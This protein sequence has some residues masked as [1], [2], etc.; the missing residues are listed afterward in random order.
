MYY[1]LF[2]FVD[3]FNEDLQS[4]FTSV[5]NQTEITDFTNLTSWNMEV[6][7]KF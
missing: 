4:A 7:I 3:G 5:K 6:Y 2:L 1:I